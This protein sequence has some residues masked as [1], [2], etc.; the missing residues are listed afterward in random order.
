MNEPTEIG[1]YNELLKRRFG[2]Q[3][4]SGPIITLGSDIFPTKAVN[5]SALDPDDHFLLGSALGLGANAQ[6][7]VAAQIQGTIFENPANSGVIAVIEQIQYETDD[8]LFVLAHGQGV[9]IASSLIRGFK[10]DPRPVNPAGGNWP[11]TTCAVG[12]RSQVGAWGTTMAN[13]TITAGQDRVLPSTK[14]VVAPG[15]FVIVRNVNVNFFCRAHY[16]FRER[17]AGTWELNA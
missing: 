6:A 16:W 7:A 13:F 1:P 10:L 8:N 9:S 3:G 2:V 15:S 5:D 14:I 17:R 11:T 4:G 12:I